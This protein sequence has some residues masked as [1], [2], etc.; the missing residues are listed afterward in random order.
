MP[1]DAA[2]SG[3]AYGVEWTINKPF[4][5]E[6]AWDRVFI[7]PSNDTILNG[8]NVQL[9]GFIRN[10]T[11]ASTD[12][13]T[14]AVTPE[15]VTY[16][17]GNIT[18]IDE[19]TLTCSQKEG[20]LFTEPDRLFVDTTVIAAPAVGILD[21]SYYEWGKVFD[22]S[23]VRYIEGLDAE[24]PLI[25]G[26]DVETESYSLLPTDPYDITV[27]PKIYPMDIFTAVLPDTRPKV[28]LYF[29]ATFV[30]AVELFPYSETITWYQEV[31]Q[32]EYDWETYI[33]DALGTYTYFVAEEDTSDLRQFPEGY[34][35]VNPNA[36]GYVEE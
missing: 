3:L 32:K 24:T 7:N 33:A 14:G 6:D 15:T 23:R 17:L 2:A 8:F 36:P 29:T 9:R 27:D 4:G 13:T 12:P 30:G 34:P 26:A 35:A 25:D 19:L 20:D 28:V 11:P 16:G 22:Q 21:E 1:F 18:S 10:V 31:W 5:D